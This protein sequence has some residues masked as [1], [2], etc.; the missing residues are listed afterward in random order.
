MNRNLLFVSLL[1]L[2]SFSAFAQKDFESTSNTVP[3]DSNLKTKSVKGKTVV[4][5]YP[6]P[7]YGKVSVSANTSSS[8]H[9]YV[10]DM[11]GTLVFQAVLNNKT[12]KT[13]NHLEKGTYL[14]DVFEKDES[15]E[16]GKI[17]IK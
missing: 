11:E 10:F 14:Y 17:I 3:T 6:N 7:S 1:L 8:L 4:R 5:L 12:K 16:E 9:F 13:I 15:I 2:V